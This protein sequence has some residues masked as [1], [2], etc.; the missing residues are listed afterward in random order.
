MI[1]IWGGHIDVDAS[2]TF[3]Q[4]KVS[5]SLFFFSWVYI[6]QLKCYVKLVIVWFTP[7]AD[8][9]GSGG[10]CGV[11]YKVKVSSMYRIGS[12]QCN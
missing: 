3:T 11:A 1:D 7:T 5:I 2:F 6:W 4:S 9:E 10:I 12:Y 8:N